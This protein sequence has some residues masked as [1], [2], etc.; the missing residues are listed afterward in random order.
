MDHGDNDGD[1][2]HARLYGISI[3]PA[4]PQTLEKVIDKNTIYS[5]L[6]ASIWELGKGKGPF[7]VAPLSEPWV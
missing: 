1:Y 3:V 4:V 5:A 6:L 7:L 2:V